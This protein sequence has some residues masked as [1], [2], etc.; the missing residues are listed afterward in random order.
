MPPA[1]PAKLPSKMPWWTRSRAQSSTWIAPDCVRP[2]GAALP[3]ARLPTK[4]VRVIRTSADGV[5]QNGLLQ[6]KWPKA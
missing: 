2:P 4:V 1:Q 5:A 3:M 6:A